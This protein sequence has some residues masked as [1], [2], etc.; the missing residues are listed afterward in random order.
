MILLSVHLITFNNEK[1]IEE[2]LQSI[3]KQKVSFDY[4]IIIGDDCSTDKT[5]NI[6]NRYKSNYPHL[7]NIKRNEAQLGI[8]KNFKTTLDRCKGQ[9][10]FDIAGD[11]VLKHEDAL[12]KMVDTL[13]KNSKL[14]FVD[15]GYD[16]LNDKNKRI[17]PFINK[18]LINVSKNEY[19]E[20]ILLG[21]IVPISHCYNKKLLYKHVSFESYIDMN[22]TIDDYPILVDMIMHTDFQRIN[23]ALVTYRVHDDSYSHK[24]TFESHF[25][26]NNQMKILFDYF[27]KKYNYSEN[28]IKK[29]HINSYKELL[30]FAGYFEKK[31][32]GKE[33]FKK[34]KS[35]SV[36]DYVHYYASQNSF[37]RRL[38]SIL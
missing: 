26:L 11:D 8:L 15:A 4:E 18:K 36:K 35:K 3:L 7:F 5:L 14:G 17:T 30:F 9:F 10:V 27:S 29:F 19:K 31:E 12:Q 33:V 2:T 13:K 20:A 22:L 28:I 25:F 21:Q 32:L 23:E 1:H 37:F 16:R 24:K 34:L 6:I 38:I